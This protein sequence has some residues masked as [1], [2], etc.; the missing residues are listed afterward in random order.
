MMLLVNAAYLFE[1]AP[2]LEIIDGIP[3]YFNVIALLIL[4][5]LQA[6]FSTWVPDANERYY[7]GMA[8]DCLLGL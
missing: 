2:Y 7:N 4:S 8:F 3:D 5:I 1:N 6:S